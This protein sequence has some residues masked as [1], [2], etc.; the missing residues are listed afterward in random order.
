MD[1]ERPRWGV[2]INAMILLVVIA[3]LAT[4]L[5]VEQMKRAEAKRLAEARLAAAV[6]EAQRGAADAR[7]E[8]KRADAE[9]MQ[10]EVRFRK[11]IDDAK[12]SGRR[13][14]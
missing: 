5:V 3:A 1:H 11:P 14:E 13:R 12:G 7:A 10:V 8:A 2:R 4:A 9:G 6:A